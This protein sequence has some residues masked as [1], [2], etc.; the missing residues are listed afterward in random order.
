[1]ICISLPATSIT[2]T[3]T[4]HESIKSKKSLKQKLKRRKKGE[5]VYQIQFERFS[6]NFYNISADS[7]QTS[8]AH[9]A[10]FSTIDSVSSTSDQEY[11]LEEVFSDIELWIAAQKSEKT[12]Q[13]LE[14]RAD[15][16]ENLDEVEGM[17]WAVTLRPRRVKYNL[18]DSLWI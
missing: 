13:I 8:S 14:D 15:I 4:T 1:M 12:M 16:F 7:L 18:C 9:D 3:I 6:E 2:S 10:S 5:A 17:D 11:L